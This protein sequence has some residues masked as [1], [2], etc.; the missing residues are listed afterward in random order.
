VSNDPGRNGK[1][2]GLRFAVKLSYQDA[3]LDTGGSRF[4]SSAI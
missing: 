3:R 2:E 4:R 1:P